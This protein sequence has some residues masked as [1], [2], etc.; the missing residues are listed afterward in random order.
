M[1]AEPVERER[2]Q[3]VTSVSGNE[4][5]TSLVG[6]VLL[7]LLFLIGITAFGI[8]QLLPQHFLLGFLLLPPIGLKLV[9]TGYRFARYYA[10][11]A[12][13]R[14]AGPPELAMR[15]IAPV[16]V[17]S[18]IAVFATGLE[19]WLFGLRFGS[20]WVAAH[21]LSFLVWLPFI[22]L[23]TLT[24]VNRS[25][26][27]VRRELSSPPAHG[28]VTRRSLLI[29]SLVAGAVLAIASLSYPSPFI[30]FGEG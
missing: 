28:A 29:G 10:G 18:T 23:H 13:Y 30:F 2:D 19:L 24:Y 12:A 6:A 16:V 21:K 17:V 7:V 22:A 26:E 1:A 27:A 14:R 15:L 25:T 5:L 20:I 4:R 8:R 3:S 11:D 9:S